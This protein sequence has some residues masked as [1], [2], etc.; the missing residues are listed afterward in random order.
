MSAETF[1][2]LPL[3]TSH[4]ELRRVHNTAGEFLVKQGGK[5]HS[6]MTCSHNEDTE[7]VDNAKW[8]VATD[9][10]CRRL[11]IPWCEDCDV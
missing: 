5:A 11:G 7:F 2:D 9:M 8:R 6:S 3:I 4:D 1:R 10:E